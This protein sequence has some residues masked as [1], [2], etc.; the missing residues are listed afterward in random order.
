VIRITLAGPR[1]KSDHL[2]SGLLSI[3]K[4]VFLAIYCPTKIKQRTNNF[5]PQALFIIKQPERL[6][7]FMPNNVYSNSI[8]FFKNLEKNMVTALKHVHCYLCN[9]R[10]HYEVSSSQYDAAGQPLSPDAC[11]SNIS[12]LGTHRLFTIC[13]WVAGADKVPVLFEEAAFITNPER[14]GYFIPNFG[15][16]VGENIIVCSD[17]LD[18]FTNKVWANEN[19]R[20]KLCKT[21]L[22]KLTARLK[23]LLLLLWKLDIIGTAPKTEESF[24]KLPPGQQTE[25]LDMFGV[26][27]SQLNR[28]Y[29]TDQVKLTLH[30]LA[31]IQTLLID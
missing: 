12:G 27:I 7:D 19:F 16:L 14:E 4:I 23:C 21:F 29:P 30:K 20:D 28:M 18:E 11:V 6:L 1:L 13:P 25:I 31:L 22:N 2:K 9:K 5:L 3:K 8:L 17:C 10:L 26:L 15:E 24:K